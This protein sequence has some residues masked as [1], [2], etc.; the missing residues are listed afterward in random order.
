MS[1]VTINNAV[2][3]YDAIKLLLVGRGWHIDHEAVERA[4]GEVHEFVH[5]ESGKKMVWLEAFWA[6]QDRE[7]DSAA[8]FRA[9]AHKWVH[10]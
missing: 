1:S 10:R 2:P 7:L 3:I 5:P 4:D 6:E 9:K 8:A